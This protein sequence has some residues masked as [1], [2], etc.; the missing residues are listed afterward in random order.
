MKRS[1]LHMLPV[2]A[3]NIAISLYGYNLYRQRYGQ[4]YKEY[5]KQLLQNQNKSLSVLEREQNEELCGFIKYAQ[6][7]SSFYRDLYAGIDL[8]QITSV[9]DL[10]ILPVVDKEM[11]RTNIESVY[12]VSQKDS[13]A[14]F[15]G[16]TTGK[17][18]QVRFTKKDFQKR[19][20]YLDV[21]KIRLGVDPFKS[22]KAT[23][24]GREILERSDSNKIF[25]RNNWAYKQRLYSTFDLTSKNIPLYIKDLNRFKPEIINGFVSAIYEIASFAEAN[26]M[27]FNFTPEAIFTTSET[28]LPHHRSLIERVFGCHV[29]NQYASAEGA[30]FITEC[31]HGQLH[32]CIDTGVIETMS[33]PAGN[34]M[35]ITSF[36]THGTPLI[37]YKIGDL[38]EFKD[39]SCTCGSNH[40]LVNKIEGRM[41]DSL[42]SEKYG[43]ISLSH[44]SDVIKGLPNCV[45]NVQFQQIAK[46]K[47]IV[48]LAVDEKQYNVS[49]EQ[50]IQNALHYRFGSETEFVFKRVDSIPR[51]KSG[52]RALIKNHIKSNR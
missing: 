6:K 50:K 3:Q 48:L 42:E 47:I 45:K 36:T 35:L 33:T 32:Y 27:R 31:A 38:V 14:S 52:K 21:F 9:E 43:K 11:L 19:M 25:W 24:S 28:L 41:V 20:A 10:G 51:E 26:N 4:E 7:H 18:I 46:N 22:K 17:A 37:R 40:P 1:A 2:F 34:E 49:T 8:N 30:S 5:K 44:L 23:F 16:G 12:T 13:I 15:T 29:Y 39:G